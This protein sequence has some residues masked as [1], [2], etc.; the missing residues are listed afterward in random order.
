MI[1]LWILWTFIPVIWG[2]HS[3]SFSPGWVNAHA[4]NTQAECK[5]RIRSVDVRTQIDMTEI[6]KCL[7]EDQP[8]PGPVS[9]VLE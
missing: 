2:N 9:E 1:K 4:F 8:P 7:Q 3:R 5:E 6:M